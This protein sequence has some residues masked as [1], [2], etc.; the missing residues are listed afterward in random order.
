MP[1]PHAPSCDRNREP[2][3]S[4]IQPLLADRQRVLELGSGTGQH[5]AWFARQ[6]PHLSWQTTE[7]PGHLDGIHQWLADA[8]LPNTPPP[9]ALDV[10]ASPWPLPAPPDQAFDAAFTANTTIFFSDNEYV[11]GAFNTGE[12]YSKWVSGSN[13]IAAG[14]VIRFTSIDTTSLAAS[15]GSFTRET[16]ASNTNWGLAAS[17]ETIY[18]YQGGSATAPTSFLAAIT[19]GD[20]AVDGP[21]TGTGLVEGSTAIRLNANTPTATPDYGVYNGVR[22]GLSSFASYLPLLNNPA[23]WTVDTTNGV[24]ATTVPDT[25]AFSIAQTTPAVPEP[26]S[27][28]LALLSLGVMGAVARRRSQR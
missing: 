10:A 28:A 21:L 1:R 19:N 7:R 13:A 14:S 3:L 23:N 20:F 5:A 15:L 4:V 8:A 18:A 12:S 22:S 26:E 27:F 2:I 17:N 6:M 24:Y 9:I 25:T 11:S 16:V